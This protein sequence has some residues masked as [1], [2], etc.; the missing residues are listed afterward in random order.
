M[1]KKLKVLWFAAYPY[2]L[3]VAKTKSK[4]HPVPWITS[5]A[6][7]IKKDV[8][9][10]I[11]NYHWRI[12]KIVKIEKDGINF[13]FLPIPNIIIDILT[14]KLIKIYRIRNWIKENEKN[15]DL[16]HINGT[17]YQFGN[18]VGKVNI[19]VI[20]SIQGV[21]SEVKKYWKPKLSIIYLS[22]LIDSFY[23][24]RELRRRE[25]F[26]CRTHWDEGI[27]LNNNKYAK[28][29][30]NWEI[31]RSQ[32][33]PMQSNNYESYNL[34]YVGGFNPIKGYKEALLAFKCLHE[35][36][37]RYKLII[38]GHASEELL[39]HLKDK[40]NLYN[41]YQNISLTGL[42]DAEE[43]V[44]L[45]EQSFCLLHPTYID[46]SPNSVC[47]AQ[48]SGL[49]VIASNVGGVSSLI[50]EGKSGLLVENKSVDEIVKSVLRL[51][52]DPK[53]YMEIS[54]NAIGI[55]QTR[56]NKDIIVHKLLKTYKELVN[57]N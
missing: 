56:H 29:F 36:D 6:E 20:V 15:F 46:N 1:N 16:I 53:L 11:C 4:F 5:L 51:K 37:N 26:I 35:L 38:C 39:I 32:F 50:N 13:V 31:I 17:E 21:L 34:I 49:P 28:I 18:G 19:P 27:V 3:V 47:E 10:T 55:A 30:H 52:D 45:F 54:N 9:L 40:L 24:K 42:I 48:I 43:M 33:N 41:S 12:N 23:E 25:N 7:L 8:D 2:D 14:L 22:W 57:E 44:K